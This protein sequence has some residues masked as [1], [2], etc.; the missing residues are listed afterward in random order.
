[1]PRW[2]E[3]EQ[4][5]EATWNAREDRIAELEAENNTLR[6]VLAASK[7][8]CPY[9]NLAAQDMAKCAHGFPGCSRADDMNL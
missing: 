7:A 5:N 6:R 9:C 8:D 1:M 4:V 2:D 3:V